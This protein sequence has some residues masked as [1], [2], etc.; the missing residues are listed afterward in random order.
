VKEKSE[1][2]LSAICQIGIIIFFAVY[3]LIRI[4]EKAASNFIIANALA[5][6]CLIIATFW[7]LDY[8]I[9]FNRKK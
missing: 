2:L 5:L 3:N 7:F 4:S 8:S 1:Y 6:V 9:H